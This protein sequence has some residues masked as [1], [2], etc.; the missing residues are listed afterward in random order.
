[1][2]ILMQINIALGGKSFLNFG[3]YNYLAFA[4]LLVTSFFAT[5]I[6][7]NYMAELTNSIMYSMELSVIQKVRNAS[8]A[9]FEK[10]G[11]NRL[12]AAISDAR[13]LSRVP[14][15]FVTILNSSITLF[16]SLLYLFWISLWG[17]ITVLGLMLVLLLIYLYRNN[18]I[19]RKLN[20]VRDLQDSYYKSLWELMVGF[21]QIR[22]SSLRNR[23][24]FEK[25]ILTN[26]NN[27]KKLSTDV[28]KKYVVNELIG[29]YSWFLVIGVIIFAL[30]AIFNIT[31]L[32]LAVFLTTV[33]FMMSPVSQLII[34][35]PSLTG[36]RIAV[37]RINQIDKDLVVDA[38]PPVTNTSLTKDFESIRFENVVYRYNQQ[39]TVSFQLELPDFTIHK[40]EIIFVVGG[41]GSGK[42]TF[43]SLLTALCRPTDGKVFIDGKE[44]GWEDMSAYSNNMAVVYSDHYLFKENYDEHDLAESNDDKNAFMQLVNLDGIAKVD[45]QK[46]AFD[47]K[48]SK[49]Q[50]KRLALLLA[51]MEDKPILILDEWAAE[52]D[53]LNR[54]MFYSEWLPIIRNMGKT[55]IAV[56]HDDDFYHLADRVVKF[57]YGKITTETEMALE[58]NNETMPS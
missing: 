44:V 55:I 14:E 26:R 58:E 25:F 17:G 34:F 29:V 5:L 3:E 19:E 2:G 45:Q 57:N 13:I 38:L 33:L 41:N 36:F 21:K 47:T 23:N 16:C 46:N 28:S 11:S 37:D 52:Q 24:I 27:A 8:Y 4:V 32:Q 48:L 7:Q 9:S 15:I 10:L 12:Y 35:V 51:L 43:I 22:I 20:A 30:P 49:G 53:P 6:F 31:A 50:Q 42:T 40:G 39:D 56:S 18:K 1:M 54:R